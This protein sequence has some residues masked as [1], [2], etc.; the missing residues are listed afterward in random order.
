[1]TDLETPPLPDAGAEEGT[2]L[3]DL[4]VLTEEAEDAALAEEAPTRPEDGTLTKAGLVRDTQ[5]AAE[6]A[7][8]ERVETRATAETS[9]ETEEI[10][11][12]AETAEE[13]LAEIREKAEIAEDTRPREAEDPETTAREGTTARRSPQETTD[14]TEAL[15]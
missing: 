6:I 12:I 10:E 8:E 13:E 7:E 2:P 14:L 9:K 1:V 4:L 3:V 15:L 11:V 5:D